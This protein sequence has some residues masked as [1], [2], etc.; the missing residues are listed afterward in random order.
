M[1]ELGV[2]VDVAAVEVTAIANEEHVL[3][4]A[5]SALVTSVVVIL[6]G[7]H[8]FLRFHHHLLRLLDRP[9]LPSDQFKDV[10]EW[11][12]AAW[13]GRR[14]L[15][16]LLNAVK[17]KFMQARQASPYW[18]V[19]IEADG[20][21]N[22]DAA[23]LLVS[24]FCCFLKLLASRCSHFFLGGCFLGCLLD[25]LG[26]QHLPLLVFIVIF[27]LRGG[28]WIPVDAFGGVFGFALS[29]GGCGKDLA[30]GI[31]A[32]VVEG[33]VGVELCV[34]GIVLVIGH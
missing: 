33:G 23:A 6:T 27:I 21:H 17:T 3:V 2:T 18:A 12:T 8:E 7:K 15:A 22:L 29:G 28:I 26:Q 10:F 16:P 5:Q 9:L 11:P 20:A 1:A 31:D 30:G 25:G 19:S 13:A 34:E 14:C 4:V 32:C 24:D